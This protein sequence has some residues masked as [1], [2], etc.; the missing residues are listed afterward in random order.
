MGKLVPRPLKIDAE[1]AAATNRDT[2]WPVH[3]FRRGKNQRAG[4]D[5]RSARKRFVLDAA[6]VSS[7]EN[8]L[9]AAFLDKIHVCARRRKHFVTPDRFASPANIG[10][11]NLGNG[12]NYVWHAGVDEMRALFLAIRDEFDLKPQ[13]FR[14]GH[15]QSD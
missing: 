10:I 1:L 12:H 6:L 4:N 15:V 9:R 7:Q 5:T 2:D 14:A 3:L 8:F 11:V 13:I